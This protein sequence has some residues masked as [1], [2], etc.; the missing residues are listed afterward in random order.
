MPTPIVSI[1]KVNVSPIQL[2]AI[3]AKKSQQ[4]LNSTPELVLV[5]NLQYSLRGSWG[6]PWKKITSYKKMKPPKEDAVALSLQVFM[7]LQVLALLSNSYISQDQASIL[8][9]GTCSYSLFKASTFDNKAAWHCEKHNFLATTS[10]IISMLCLCFFNL[11]HP[12][13]EGQ[14]RISAIPTY[15]PFSQ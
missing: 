14:H 8:Y 1:S 13:Y 9:A 3:K 12:Q 7:C 11:P 10:G 6:Q 4:A 5:Q 15:N 2:Q